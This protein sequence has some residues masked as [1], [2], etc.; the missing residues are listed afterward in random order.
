MKVIT[1]YPIAI[2]SPDHLYPWGTAYDNH[3]NLG[4]IAEVE[5]YF[6]NK[7][8]INFLDIGCSG[9]QL[10]VDFCERGHLSVGIEGSNYSVVNE[11]ANWPEYHNKNLFTCDASKP[12]KIVDDNNEKIIFD[13]ISSWEVIEHISPDDLGI[14]FK[15]IYDHMSEESIFVGGI[16]LISDCHT[17]NGRYETPVELHQSVFPKEY[18][19]DVIL[20][21]LFNVE[22]YPFSNKVRDEDSSFY[23]KLTKKNG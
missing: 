1:D 9:G 13:C 10:A 22:E 14:F 21:K 4:F 20:S 5:N 8:K 6:T 12:Y 17:C 3:T 7:E 18:W 16:S 15:N 19:I 23:I 2:D 11:R